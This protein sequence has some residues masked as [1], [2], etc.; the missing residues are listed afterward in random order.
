MPSLAAGLAVA[1]LVV[2]GAVGSDLRM[3]YTALG[4][5]INL[6]LHTDGEGWEQFGFVPNTGVYNNY[7]RD[8]QTSIDAFDPI[9]FAREAAAV[10]PVHF[11][12]VT[13]DLVVPNSAN[14]IIN[15]PSPTRATT[16]RSGQ[17]R[18][19][20]R[21]RGSPWPMAPPVSVSHAW[22]FA[23]SMYW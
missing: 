6:W 5:A 22:A 3:E 14:I 12:Q 2:V 8:L 13:G 7:V 1:G 21:A 19:A 23:F 9:S 4:N 20:P 16:L 18:E 15:V 10:H 17:A 11:I